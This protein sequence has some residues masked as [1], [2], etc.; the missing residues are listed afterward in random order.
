[1][2]TTDCR[3]ERQTKSRRKKLAKIWQ[4]KEWK[5]KKAI[6]IKGKVCSWCG[7]DKKL[8][9]HHPY[10]NSLSEGIYLDF[11]LS[12]CVVLC[13]RCHFALH[14]GKKL[15]P[16]CKEHYCSFDTEMCYPCYVKL[17][18]EIE[19]ARVKKKEEM[20]ALQKKLRKQAREKA[21]LKYKK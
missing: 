21:K 2:T 12:G 15:C 8:L 17:H 5:E 13:T 9:P 10:I 6:F 19:E 14:H 20:R 4:T 18:P 11:Y 16:T 1:M 7:T 3:E